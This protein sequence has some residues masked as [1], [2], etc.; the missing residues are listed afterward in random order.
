MGKS[1]LQINKFDLYMV[2]LKQAIKQE[3]MAT[4]SMVILKMGFKNRNGHLLIYKKYVY[5]KSIN[6]TP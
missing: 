3:V 2:Q 4:K 5:L 6:S 1:K